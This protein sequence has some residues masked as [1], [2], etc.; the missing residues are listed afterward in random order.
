VPVGRRWFRNNG[1][2]PP[3]SQA[4]LSGRYLS[5]TER[6]EISIQRAKGMGVRQIA[7]KLGRACSTISRELRRN[8]ATRCGRLEYRATTAQWH[9]DRRAQRPKVPKLSA[10]RALGQYVQDRLAGTLT[11]ANGR[12]VH[13]PEVPWTNRRRGRRQNRR[14]AKSWSPEQIARR[15]CLDFPD[16]TEMR[17]SHEAIYQALYIKGRAALRRE[18]AACLR[19]GRTL[20]MPRARNRR[21]GKAFVGPENMIRQ[22]PLEAESRTVAGHWEVSARRRTG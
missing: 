9:A 18:W 17:I 1:G 10:N 8:A 7:Y 20:R 13:G 11:D 14:W 16:K 6:E 3:I 12:Q 2:M 21:R 4:P 5:F 22:R 19:T 15:L